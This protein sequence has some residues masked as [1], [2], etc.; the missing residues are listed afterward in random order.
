MDISEVDVEN[1]TVNERV[2][3][4]RDAE[5]RSL[6]LRLLN[7]IGA[8]AGRLGMQLASLEPDSI[9]AAAKQ[10]TGVNDL[11]TAYFG[12]DCRE[13]LERFVASCEAQAQLTTL[14]RFAVRNMLVNALS[15]RLQ[16]VDWRTRHPQIAEE[17]IVKPWIVLGLP[18]TGT[19]L[20]NALLGLA[21]TSRPLL[22]W[23]AARPMPPAD[24]ATAGEDARI[25]AFVKDM[26][27]ALK[28]NP[29]L[30]AMHPFG[31]TLAE[32]CTAVFMYA[33][34]TIGLEAIS[35]VPDYGRWLDD[36]D[37]TSTYAIHKTLLQALQAAQPTEQWVLKSPNHLWCLGEMLAAYPDARIIWTHR[38][39][40]AVVTSLA[41]INSAMQLPFTRRKDM[42]P[43]GEYWADKVSG[44]IAKATAFDTQQTPGWCYHLNY[45]DLIANPTAAVESIYQHFGETLA[46]LHRRRIGAWLQY[47]PQA[48]FGRH[49]YD[50]RDFGWDLNGLQQRYRDYRERYAIPAASKT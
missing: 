7:T 46:P 1:H 11:G 41:S 12:D 25:Q 26:Q 39:P 34:R 33:L 2:Y 29:G 5:L 27:G 45:E 18:R 16:L 31:S 37:M 8:G 30:G 44:G 49:G 50:A 48:A 9:V 15:N 24:L 28:L 40:A 21:P 32:E 3:T 42:R 4:Y 43:V 36:A 22:Q 19:S 20:L 10:R 6:P 17:R 35:F 47:R 13:P 38:D 14:G 23:E